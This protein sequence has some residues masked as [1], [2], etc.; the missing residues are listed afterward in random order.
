MALTVHPLTAEHWPAL[1]AVL[2]PDGARGCWCMYWRIGRG[3]RERTRAENRADFKALVSHGPPPGLIAF[4]DETPV[5]WCQVGP[6][7]ALPGLASAWRLAPVDDAPVWAL[8]CLYCAR[9]G[10]G[11]ESTPC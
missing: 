1:E 4:D 6:R 9:A 8:S 5:G 10:D 2:G 3:Y 11:A 7:A